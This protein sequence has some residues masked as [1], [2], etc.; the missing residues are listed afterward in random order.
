[1]CADSLVMVREARYGQILSAG[2]WFRLDSTDLVLSQSGS[3][4][5]RFRR[6]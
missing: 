6:R 1:M 3:E 4:V 2:G 5:A